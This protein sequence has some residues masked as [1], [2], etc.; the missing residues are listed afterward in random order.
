MHTEVVYGALKSQHYATLEDLYSDDYMLVRPDGSVLNRQE[1]V[2][3]LR[4]N[5]LTFHAIALC[6]S[7]GRILRAN[8]GADGRKQNRH[9]LERS[10]GSCTLSTHCGLCARGRVNQACARS[11]HRPA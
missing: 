10:G 1:V 5:R 3:D 2:Q 7:K 11:K 6:Q 8:S 9:L 4:T